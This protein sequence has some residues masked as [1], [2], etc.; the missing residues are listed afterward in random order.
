MNLRTATIVRMMIVMIAMTMIFKAALAHEHEDHDGHEENGELLVL[1]DIERS[2]AGIEIDAVKHK[3]ISERLLLPG[4]VIPN[5]YRSAKVAPRITAQVVKRHAR[6]GEHVQAGQSMVTLSSVEMADAQGAL[7]VAD[8]EWRRVQ[9]LGKDVV[10][11]GRYTEAQVARQ[12]AMAKVLAF[13]M[14]GSHVRDLLA[15]GDVSRATGEFELTAPI[16]GTVLTDDFVI[17]ELIGPGRILFEITDETTLWI[18]ARTSANKIAGISIGAPARISPDQV[19]WRDATVIQ[20]HHRLEE[21]TRTQAIRVEVANENDW[22]HPG[23]FVE[24][25]VAAGSRHEVL[26]VPSESIVL[27]KGT[28]VV[29]RLEEN[30][31]FHPEPVRTGN[32]FGEWSEVVNGLEE[33]DIIATAGAFFLKS[34]VL[35]SELGE[36]HAH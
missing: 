26:A 28:T 3:L 34:L 18:E 6:L 25:E 2:A 17:G 11:A 27:L 12:A 14:I 31:E 29:F 20:I 8:Q 24:V 4:E 1:T 30:D 15:T 32:T 23:Q 16:S 10:S 22:L 5:A 13:G 36:G 7:L 33:G 19:R 35:K 9:T 21:A